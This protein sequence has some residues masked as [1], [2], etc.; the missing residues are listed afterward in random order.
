MRITG[1]LPHFHFLIFLF[2]GCLAAQS[3]WLFV[4][5]VCSPPGYSVH[6]IFQ[7]RMLVWVA[8]FLLQGIF[9]TWGMNPCILHCRQV[10]YPL[11]HS[12]KSNLLPFRTCPSSIPASSSKHLFSKEYQNHWSLLFASKLNQF[13]NAF[14]L[15]GFPD[16]W[17]G[18]EST[19]NA[20][21]PGSIPGSG[22]SAGEG[23]GYPLQH[24][25]L[26][27]SMDV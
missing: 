13:Y 2:C 1:V 5:F 4:T 9:L 16:S 11:S 22:K 26:E 18:E 24:S 12:L 6:R 27:N 14:S 19:C 17:V 15:H 21:D 25:S 20:G 10:L 3:I 8:L 7:A 23:I